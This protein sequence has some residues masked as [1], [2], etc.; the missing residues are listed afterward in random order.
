MK[1]KIF[2]DF[3]GVISNTN[4]I[5]EK[6][7]KNA[8]KKILG[9]QDELFIKYFTTNNGIPRELKLK[10]YFNDEKL[11]KK[12]LDKYSDLNNN[13]DNAEL[14]LGL[15]DFL[16]INKDE[17]LFILSGGDLNEI[18]YLLKKNNILNY[19]SDVLTGPKTK[20]Q[21]LSSIK[22]NSHDFFIGDSNHDYQ[23]SKKF[24]LKFIFMT[25]FSQ[26]KYPYN[27]LDYKVQITKNFLTLINNNE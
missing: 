12:I 7:I 17:N 11:E 5:K 14:N 2:I 9:K 20:S 4:F 25:D 23:V 16:E 24:N 15:L 13:L 27:F 8:T 6:N 10:S 22:L 3:D 19:F 18:E 26:E 1:K 21:H